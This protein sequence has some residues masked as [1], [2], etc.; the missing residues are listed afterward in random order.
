MPLIFAELHLIQT[1]LISTLPALVSD[2]LG[3]VAVLQAILHFIV[4]IY[5]NKMLCNVDK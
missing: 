5:G 4:K 3:W 2:L 1:G